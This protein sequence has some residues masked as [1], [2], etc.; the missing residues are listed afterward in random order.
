MIFNK[1]NEGTVKIRAVPSLFSVIFINFV[2]IKQYKKKA[3]NK[4]S[5]ING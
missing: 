2:T 5:N 4:Y 1:N 3:I